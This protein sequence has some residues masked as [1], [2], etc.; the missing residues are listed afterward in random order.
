MVGV[1]KDY[2]RIKKKKKHKSVKLV[3]LIGDCRD[4]GLKRAKVKDTFKEQQQ[5][6][7][8]SMVVGDDSS[9]NSD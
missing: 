3:H 5:K 9:G 8:S 2:S 7:Y 1:K 6:K 4:G